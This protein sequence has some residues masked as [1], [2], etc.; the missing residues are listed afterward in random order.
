MFIWTTRSN[1]ASKFVPSVGMIDQY[2]RCYQML[3]SANL[4]FI[5]LI[6]LLEQKY[7]KLTK[8]AFIN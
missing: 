7:K 8:G 3:A 6:S 4:L 1:K 2:I 5:Y